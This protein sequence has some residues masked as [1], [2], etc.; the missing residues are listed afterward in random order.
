MTGGNAPNVARRV[1]SWGD[2]WMPNR[3][4]PEQLNA[5]REEIVRLAQEAGRDPHEIEVS[6]F[7]QPG[8]PEVLKAYEDAGATRA[9]VFADS[10]PR[11]DA[12]RQLDD[13]ARRLLA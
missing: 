10:A 9:M 8:D 2:G 5:G 6:V 12:L 13:Y 7:G 11:D 4:T 3:I 1:V